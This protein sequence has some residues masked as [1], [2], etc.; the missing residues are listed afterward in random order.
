M[1]LAIQLLFA[2]LCLVYTR[3]KPIVTKR[4]SYEAGQNQQRLIAARARQ[5]AE[6][7]ALAERGAPHGRAPAAQA[8]HEL[9]EKLTLAPST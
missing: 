6:K 1:L 4:L 5:R 2:I 8:V 7:A 9:H 3:R